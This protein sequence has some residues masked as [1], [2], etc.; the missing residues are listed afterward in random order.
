[1]SK[2]RKPKG[3]QLSNRLTAKFCA[4]I[5]QPGMYADGAT[6]YLDW[7]S[8]TS[9]S[10]VQRLLVKRKPT[11]LGLGSYPM[12]SLAQARA[13]AAYNRKIA[14]EGGDP[15]FEKRAAMMPTFSECAERVIELYAEGWKESGKSAAQWRASLQKY[16]FPII[17][18]KRVD[19]VTVSDVMRVLSPHWANKHVT[20]NRVRRRISAVMK[21]AI[22]EGYREDNPAGEAISAALPKPQKRAQHFK[23]LPYAELP[24]AIVHIQQCGAWAATTRALEF[25]ILT[26]TRSIEACGADWSEIDVDTKTWTIPAERMKAGREHKIPLSGR[27]LAI[28]Q[29]Q[30]E[31]TGGDG[32]VFLSA[33]GKPLS[34][35]ALARVV[36]L[37]GIESTCHGFRSTF[38]DWCAETGK[39]R[40]LA[41]AALAH[42]VGGVEGAYFRTRLLEERHSLMD[43][44]SN[45]ITGESP[46]VVAFPHRPAER[47]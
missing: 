37:A 20:M 15:L 16:A 39:R 45:F 2:G 31:A 25:L 3:P 38:R 14:R 11:R 35:V 46:T 28:L 44:W 6:L 33:T 23:A 17:G 18:E 26:A 4:A 8:P 10:W 29:E 22:A 41:E 27:S 36:R 47:N 24:I 13:D 21:W 19:A 32:L 42:T 5:T 9:R 1:M 30:R 34:S 40:E 7:R 43:A 12:R